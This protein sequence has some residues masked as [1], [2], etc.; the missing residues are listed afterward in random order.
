[1][2]KQSKGKKRAPAKRKSAAL[3]PMQGKNAEMVDAGSLYAEVRAI[4]NEARGRAARLVNVEMVRAYWL[5]G[6]AIVKHE[7]RGENRAGYGEQLIESLAER[8]TAELS[9]GFQ[10]RNLWWMRD[11]YLKSPILNALRSELSWTHYRLLLKVDRPEARAF[12]EQEAAEQNW[13]TR[14]W[15]GR[16]ARC[17]MSA[18]L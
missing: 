13:S 1:V 15:S 3:A 5:V 8:L 9:K 6:Q 4:L 14:E 16:S 12:Y 11:F 7:Q 18:R 17:Y 10:S 2:K